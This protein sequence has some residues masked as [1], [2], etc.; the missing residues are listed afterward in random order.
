V[1]LFSFNKK[2]YLF[3]LFSDDWTRELD[4]Q[5][6]PIPDYKE[7]PPLRTTN[8]LQYHDL[9]SDVQGRLLADVNQELLDFETQNMMTDLNVQGLSNRV[10]LFINISYLVLNITFYRLTILIIICKEI[11]LNI[12]L[13]KNM[14]KIK[15]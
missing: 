11:K 9:P 2:N 4:H 5:R 3:S 10:N 6:R 8:R 1:K 12:I 7:I 15:Y 13:L 14:H